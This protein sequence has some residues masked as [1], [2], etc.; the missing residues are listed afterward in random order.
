M[1]LGLLMLWLN[2]LKW[3]E[4]ELHG[5]LRRRHHH[6][7]AA[8]VD[9]RIKIAMSSCSFCTYRHGR[10]AVDHCICGYLPGVLKYFE[11]GDLAGLI[12]PRAFIVV[13]GEKDHLSP[14]AGVREALGLL[15]MARTK[16]RRTFIPLEN[17]PTF[18][19]RY[20]QSPTLSINSWIS[21]AFL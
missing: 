9:E 4:N 8:C 17:S 11:M 16:F 15:S 10:C 7:Y 20:S 5:Q 12:A 14:I 18:R 13:A 2:F 19:S 21:A 6:L 3:T 1:F